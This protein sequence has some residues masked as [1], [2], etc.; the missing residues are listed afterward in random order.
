LLNEIF[1]FLTGQEVL[2]QIAIL[3]KRVR[4]NVLMKGGPL[5][6]DRVVALGG[7]KKKLDG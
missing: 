4:N 2:I 7:A 3:N 6:L 1:A 5:K